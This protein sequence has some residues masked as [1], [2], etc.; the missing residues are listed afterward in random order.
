[1][2]KDEF[3]KVLDAWN[4]NYIIQYFDE[5]R[6]NWYDWLEKTNP[7]YY[8]QCLYRVHPKN[9]KYENRYRNPNT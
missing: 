7:P 4:L 2:Y 1:M 6:R 9:L 3:L 8:P 5:D